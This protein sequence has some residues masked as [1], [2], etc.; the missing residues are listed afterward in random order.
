MSATVTYSRYPGIRS[1]QAA[2]RPLFFG[3]S[4]ETRELYSLIK[5][6]RFVVLF[7]KSGMG[8]TSL[9]NAGVLPR[10]EEDG[11]VATQVR[12]QNTQIAP[13]EML[14][15]ALAAQMKEQGLDKMVDKRLQDWCEEREPSLW[16][17]FKACSMVLEYLPAKPLLVFDQFEE[18]FLHSEEE[19]SDLVDFMADL[20]FARI[21]KDVQEA[22]RALE[23]PSFRDEQWLEPLDW[24]LIMAIRSDKL[25]LLE[26]LSKDI[27]AILDHRYQLLPL[28]KETA[29]DAVVLPARS[30]AYDFD[31]PAFEYDDKALDEILTQLSNERGEIE[32]FQLQ[33]VCRHLEELV[34]AKDLKVVRSEHIGGAAGITNILNNYYEDRV[35]TFGTE[36]EQLKA[37][38]LIE[39]GLIVDGARVGLAEAIL[40]QRYD[41]SPE[42][43]AR[44]ESTRI[45]KPENTHLGRAY[46]V[47]HD[48]LVEPIL[49]SYKERQAK[50]QQ[51]AAEEERRRLEKQAALERRKRRRANIFLIGAVL[52]SLVSIVSAVWA[53]KSGQEAA[54]ARDAMRESLTREKETLAQVQAEKERAEAA[55]KQAEA[56]L[57]KRNEAEL[58]TLSE[59][60]VVIIQAGGCP[61]AILQKIQGIVESE[62]SNE[63]MQ[64]HFE[65]LNAK[66]P[67]CL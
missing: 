38:R 53:W 57:I 67:G 59:R 56:A 36:E 16:E 24:K 28:N 40:F 25:S 27:P 19:E 29:S 12:F 3:R 37:R 48:T 9:L 46:E 14:R 2:E 33:I 49:R 1:F 11:F 66:A 41:I 39:E 51:R 10:L 62:Y 64:Q 6:E 26:S 42:L 17:Y 54:I 44:M 31:S 60:A 58:N 34:T 52:L 7:S 30:E 63:A 61:Q 32:S 18:F 23:E 35:A 4:Q 47:S 45:I 43:L 55:Q 21:P 13:K 5:V 22:Y 65:Q 50:E 8:K 20:L 15:S